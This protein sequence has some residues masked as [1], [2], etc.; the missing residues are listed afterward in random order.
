MQ[1]AHRLVENLVAFLKEISDVKASQC[2]GDCC[3]YDISHLPLTLTG[4]DSEAL[5][6]AI[7]IGAKENSMI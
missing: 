5:H 2:F 7:H 3:S 1:R 6:D 4:N